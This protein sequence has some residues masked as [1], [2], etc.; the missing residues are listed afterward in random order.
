MQERDV[1]NVLDSA[2]RHGRRD[3]WAHRARNFP[4]GLS[5][6]MDASPLNSFSVVFFFFVVPCTYVLAYIIILIEEAWKRAT[7]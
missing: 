2:R 4:D 7:N 5:T 1:L 3:D 6:C